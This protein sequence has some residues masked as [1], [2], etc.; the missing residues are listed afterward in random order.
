MKPLLKEE[1]AAPF[2][3]LSVSTLQ[4]KR[5]SGDGPLYVKIGRSVP[6]PAVELSATN[7]NEAQRFAEEL[8]REVA[9]WR[10]RQSRQKVGVRHDA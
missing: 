5:V 4:K 8:L 2:A 6:D 1:D 3:G 9:A 10:H 7:L